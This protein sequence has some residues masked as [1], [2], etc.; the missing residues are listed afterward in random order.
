[1]EEQDLVMVLKMRDEASAV[2]NRVE[3]ELRDTGA[4]SS[5]TSKQ[6]RDAARGMD[7]LGNETKETQSELKRMAQQVGQMVGGALSFY[8]L[9][10]AI[11]E[12]V[13]EYSELNSGMSDVRKT[14][15]LSAAD[16]NAM[17][18]DLQKMSVSL[19]TSTDNLTEF[20]ATAGRAGITGKQEIMAFTK[21][22]AE[23]QLALDGIDPEAFLR[24]LGN[25]STP[26]SQINEVAA[27]LNALDDTS[28]TSASKI[29]DLSTG[30]A[31]SGALFGIAAQD[32]MSWATILAESDVEAGI[33]STTILRL[34]TA[35]QQAAARGGEELKVLAGVAGMT[36]EQFKQ[37]AERDMAQAINAILGGLKQLNDVDRMDALK[38]FELDQLNAQ[39]AINP[40]ISK[41]EQ[42]KEARESAFNTSANQDR[43]ANEIK[44]QLEKYENV[45][46]QAQNA[47]DNFQASI[48]ADFAEALTPIL[49]A[50]TDLLVSMQEIYE[51]LPEGA[52]KFIAFGAASV[53]GL[54]A[55]VLSLG[56]VEASVTGLTTMMPGL[57]ARIAALGGVAGGGGAA[58]MLRLAAGLGA[59]AIAGGLIVG[60]VALVVGG[61]ADVMTRQEDVQVSTKDL[62]ES[63]KDLHTIMADPSASDAAKRQ[64]LQVAEANYAQ[65][66]SSREAAVAELEKRRAMA[67][68]AV[69]DVKFRVGVASEGAAAG[70][71]AAGFRASD[72]IQER[73][74]QGRVVLKADQELSLAKKELDEAKRKLGDT[75]TG[76]DKTGGGGNATFN[77]PTKTSG[78]SG[79]ASKE[80][81]DAERE[82][83]R[84]KDEQT[85][86]LAENTSLRDQLDL[87]RQRNVLTVEGALEQEQAMAVLA[88]QADLVR[89]SK[90]Q[91]TELSNAEI[92]A[93]REQV[94]LEKEK[95]DELAKQQ[96]LTNSRIDIDTAKQL[97]DIAGMEK[98]A[99]EEEEV[100]IRAKADALRNNRTLSEAELKIIREKVRAEQGLTETL[101]EQAEIRQQALD[102]ANI[103]GEMGLVQQFGDFNT[104]ESGIAGMV[105]RQTAQRRRETENPNYVPTPEEIARWRE[106]AEAQWELNEAKEIARNNADFEREVF[107]VMTDS[108]TDFITG[109]KS[110][111]EAIGGMMRALADL[112]LQY[113]V[114]IPLKRAFESAGGFGGL[115]ADGAA[116]SGGNVV[117][118]ANGGI[119][120]GPTMFPM[121]RGRTGLMGEAGPEA[122]M[123][124]KRG[125]DGKLGVASSG[126]GGGV[127]F[128]PN[129][130]VSVTD[131]RSDGDPVQ[132]G[133]IIGK[134][135]EAKMAEFTRK[136]SRP[137]GMLYKGMR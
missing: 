72:R 135:V 37:L 126:G 84:R 10:R 64:A 85:S 101:R 8:A 20:A 7:Q 73:D 123:P 34:G 77:A 106:L 14:T 4:I 15:G 5:T 80:K 132:M 93:I 131:N 29:M 50:A 71:A 45:Q 109:A 26:I 66:K 127:M 49:Q 112:V 113:L 94:R 107:A 67:A 136:E 76:P 2:L 87:I 103:K 82:A 42:L 40:L 52:Q 16:L 128:A 98:N 55:L 124:L 95:S 108:L 51:S 1:M 74:S 137:G 79:G 54:V 120:A 31:A 119:V 46:A 86:R 56:A 58:G 41:F 11:G 102:L 69:A 114:L 43:W 33:A 61:F 110:A 25:T 60:T 115:F 116:F 24:M 65:A 133:Q 97:A 91:S 47:L 57:T 62:E 28:K 3:Q 111:K 48:G 100:V 39:A 81:S 13:K 89:E 35:A 30:I 63:I 130:S 129:V 105:E 134:A 17:E 122:I 118:F 104:K 38:L 68:T 59:V 32:V 88:A 53:G 121:S 21:S 27:A 90:G 22:A 117:P 18:G 23:M 125:S 96:T 44:V 9:K 83:E 99:R 6:L 19:A 78:R 36:G 75:P 70:D 12:V 92:S